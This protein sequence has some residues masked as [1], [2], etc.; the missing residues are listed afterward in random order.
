MKKKESFWSRINKINGYTYHVSQRL[1]SLYAPLDH[2]YSR[3]LTSRENKIK[4]DSQ[5]TQ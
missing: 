3:I 5:E 1:F 4:E 2:F